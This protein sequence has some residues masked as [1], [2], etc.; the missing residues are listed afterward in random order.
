[1][2]QLP[3]HC[4]NKTLLTKCCFQSCYRS[5]LTGGKDTG[6]GEDADCAAF[7]GFV[8]LQQEGE[9]DEHPAVVDNP[10]DVDRA[11]EGDLSLWEVLY[12]SRAK[13][14]QALRL[15]RLHCL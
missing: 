8:L 15:H 2:Y 12:P 9:Q 5:S 6:D 4:V 7:P 14:G 13:Q 10:P 11:L 1:M 3:K